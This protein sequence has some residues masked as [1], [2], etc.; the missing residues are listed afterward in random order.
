MAGH[1][2]PRIVVGEILPNILA[3]VIVLET[4]GVAGAILAAS[5]LSFIGL[6][7]QV[8]SPE[9][10]A[11]LNEG[12]DYIGTQWWLATFP[13]IA[14]AITVIAVNLLGDGLRVAL[15]PRL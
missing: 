2:A 6:G 1:G 5:A 12:R 4:L 8:P 3:P 9:W 14:I 11:M 13:G 10:G 15:D 7:A